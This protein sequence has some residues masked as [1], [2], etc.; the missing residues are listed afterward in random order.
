MLARPEH[1]HIYAWFR[2]LTLGIVVG[3]KV[4]IPELNVELGGRADG[5]EDDM[6]AF[7]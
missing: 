5:G 1:L 4:E 7:G 3:N 2:F 6:T